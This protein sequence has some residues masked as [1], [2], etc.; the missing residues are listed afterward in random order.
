MQPLDIRFSQ[1]L[2]LLNADVMP[3]CVVAQI[4]LKRRQNENKSDPAFDTRNGF[5]KPVRALP[6]LSLPHLSGRFQIRGIDLGQTQMMQT[7]QTP[8]EVR[9]SERKPPYIHPASSANSI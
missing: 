6:A 4:K 3:L 8:A 2:V 9:K 1:W 5:K 7:L